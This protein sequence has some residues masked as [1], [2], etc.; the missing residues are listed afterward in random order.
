MGRRPGPAHPD[1]IGESRLL[2]S[3]HAA[4]SRDGV[5]PLGYNECMGKNNRQRRA[6]KQHK[7]SRHQPER[8]Q[9]NGQ[10]QGGR[11]PTAEDER[12]ETDPT[13]VLMAAVHAHHAGNDDRVHELVEL[14]ARLPRARVAHESQRLL[15]LQ[16]S[17]LWD[18]G[19]QPVVLD[20]VAQ[21]ELGRDETA[22]L[23]C[24]LA[25][26]SASYEVLG[27]AVA[28]DWMDQLDSVDA[29]RWWSVEVPYVFQLQGSW[30]QAL[31]SAVRV[32]NLLG[33]LPELPVLVPP[34]AQWRAGTV[35]AAGSN[36][37]TAL[38]EKVR[39]LLAKAEST[40]FDAEADAFTAKAQELMTRH[41]IDRAV[42][43]SV[44]RSD[45]SPTGRRL[46][47]D[48]PYADAKAM[49]LQAICA[50]NGGHAVWSKA[51]GFSTVFA[52]AD[53]LDII[54]DLFTSLL[55]QSSAAVRREGPK[56]D[57]LGRSRTTRF[58]RS[59]LVAFATRIGQRLQEATDSAVADAEAE[60]GR[61]LVPV[62]ASRAGA[63]HDAARDAFPELG[64]FAPAAT[65]G[66]GWFAGTLFGDRADLGVGAP[67]D[68]RAAS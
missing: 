32:M 34:P 15:E 30:P 13:T 27:R 58:R 31:R 59:F 9:H 51:L 6:A 37:P 48:D 57:R 20:R 17:R 26:D 3:A 67:L 68:E 19:W 8:N 50:A 14:L 44:P 29:I 10:Q 23:R 25:A 54:E 33:S 39:A 42:L 45:G 40:P 56:Q 65:D 18:V 41:R 7:R 61:S 60:T 49:L 62:L 28:P 16:V 53:E 4:G 21:R 11:G 63:A 38:L 35:A 52:F 46:L 47:I 66:E 12:T 43:E 1:P 24:V 55:L 5:I 36:L 2:E 64:A 22:L